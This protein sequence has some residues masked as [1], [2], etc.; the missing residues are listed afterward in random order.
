MRS[1]AVFNSTAQA[2]GQN[3]HH[4]EASRRL[5]TRRKR[6]VVGND[7]IDHRVCERQ[8]DLDRSVPAVK[9]RLSGRVCHELM[10]GQSEAPTPLRI[11]QQGAGYKGEMYPH[12][13]ERGSAH[14]GSELANVFRGIDQSVP[15]RDSPKAMNVRML[16]QQL[17]ALKLIL[18][19][20]HPLGQIVKSSL[21]LPAV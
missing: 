6:T 20:L 1:K 9:R 15:I 8:F 13:L 4:L 16:L 2:L 11:K 17:T 3:A 18:R 14:G 12:W 7:A 21:N 19:I 10:D 5:Q